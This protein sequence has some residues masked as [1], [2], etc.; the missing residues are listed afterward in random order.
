MRRSCQDCTD[1]AVPRGERPRAEEREAEEREDV[2]MLSFR[3]AVHVPFDSAV[4]DR[5]MM[6]IDPHRIRTGRQ[7]RV[8]H[9]P[10]VS[11]ARGRSV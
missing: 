8:H 3:R 9:E 2:A 10:T 1:T 7:A 11:A 5:V 6:T 4:D